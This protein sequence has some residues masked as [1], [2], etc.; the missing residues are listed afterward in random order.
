MIAAVQSFGI[1]CSV[2]LMHLIFLNGGDWFFVISCETLWNQLQIE[3]L[4]KEAIQKIEKQDLTATDIGR[5]HQMEG[6]YCTFHDQWLH[7]Q[8][9]ETMYGYS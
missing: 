7:I 6:F 1:P 2:S 9:I 8:G 3:D 4:A 5:V